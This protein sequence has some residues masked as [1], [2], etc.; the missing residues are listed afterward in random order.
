LILVPC[1]IRRKE[2][3]AV[4]VQKAFSGRGFVFVGTAVI[5]LCFFFEI[6]T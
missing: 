5:T 1:F 4:L 2:E 3:I 6:G